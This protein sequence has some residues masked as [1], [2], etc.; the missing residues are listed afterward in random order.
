VVVGEYVALLVGGQFSAPTKLASLLLSLG[1]LLLGFLLFVLDWAWKGAC[2]VFI[3]VL[4]LLP[5]L[6]TSP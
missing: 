2:T 3:S 1:E 4:F 6:P 5:T